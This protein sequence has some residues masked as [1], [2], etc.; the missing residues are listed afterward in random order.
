MSN[1]WIYV[2]EHDVWNTYKK[3]LDNNAITYIGSF[4]SYPIKAK[5]KIIIYKKTNNKIKA[6]FVGVIT[7]SRDLADNEKKIDIFDTEL[8]APYISMI[9]YC[10][11]GELIS[12]SNFDNEFKSRNWGSIKSFQAKYISKANNCCFFQIPNELGDFLFEYIDKIQDTITL[13]KENT[14]E[15][16]EQTDEE[17][18]SNKKKESIKADMGNLEKISEKKKSS[19]SSKYS[20]KSY[21]SSKKSII[22]SDNDNDENNESSEEESIIE[23][24]ISDE[25]EN[26]TEE[27]DTETKE[28]I[29]QNKLGHIPI[30]II[31]CDKFELPNIEYDK[32]KYKIWDNPDLTAKI[33]YFTEHLKKC[34]KCEVNN[35][36]TFEIIEYINKDTMD[37]SFEIMTDDNYEL[38]ESINKYELCLNYNPFGDELE[39]EFVKIVKINDA[40]NIYHNC[41]IIITANLKNKEE[42]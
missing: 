39:E 32:K 41:F 6:S 38:E 9:K 29:E 25:N 22:E 12:L 20:K 19:E 31:S 7:L 40:T 3:Y 11:Y 27:I 21:K 30:M 1:Y 16:I 42:E 18:I 24:S 17:Y 23:E 36:N 34:K 4:I 5:D 2:L 28:D 8:I 33:E 13:Q 35:N 10:N 15:E 37:V 26:D 14:I